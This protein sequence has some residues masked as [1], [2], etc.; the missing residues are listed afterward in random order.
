MDWHVRLESGTATESDQQAFERWRRADPA[1]ETAW[2]RVTGLLQDPLSLIRETGLRAPGQHQAAQ[3]AL[4]HT[5]RRRM[6]SGALMFAG[7]GGIAA[8]AIDRHTPIA[9]LMADLRTDTAQ[10]RRFMLADGS[11]VQLNARSAADVHFAAQQRRVHLREGALIAEVA[12]DHD[13]PFIVSTDFG[14]V[15]ALGT[16]FMV[17]QSHDHSQVV[18]L[19][20]DVE[21]SLRDAQRLRLSQGEGIV[22]DRHGFERIEGNALASAAWS[23]GMLVVENGTMQDVVAA[24]RPYFKGMIR[25]APEVAALR[26]FGSFPLADASDVLRT[27][28]H[29]LPIAMRQYGNWLIDLRLA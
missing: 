1:H 25:M 8:L 28:A 9:Q 12:P 2:N 11:H 4:L 17:G 18:A 29:S 5:R 26:V 6:L 3:R 7:T 14:T 22:F 24:V 15:R 13:R 27:L 16:R 10:R 21:V 20:H 23:E 19:E